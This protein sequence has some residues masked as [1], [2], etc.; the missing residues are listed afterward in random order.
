MQVD[1]SRGIELE[2]TAGDVVPFAQ[3]LGRFEDRAVF[4]GTGQNPFAAQLI[5]TGVQGHVVGFGATTGKT[6]RSGF[7]AE[8]P[9][10]LSA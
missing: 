7:H 2:Q 6:N 5:D 4:R 3:M 9:R 1:F 10:D 8:L